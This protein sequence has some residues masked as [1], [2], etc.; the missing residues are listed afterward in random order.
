MSSGEVD[1]TRE[2]PPF[3]P[4]K[5]LTDISTAALAASTSDSQVKEGEFQMA[6]ARSLSRRLGYVTHPEN[7]VVGPGSTF[8]L[9]SIIDQWRKANP[10]AR[11][12][13]PRGSRACVVAADPLWIRMDEASQKIS[14]ASLKTLLHPRDLVILS[15]PLYLWGSIASDEDI[16]ALG[17]IIYSQKAILVSDEGGWQTCRTPHASYPSLGAACPDRTIVLDSMSHKEYLPDWRIGVA[18]FGKSSILQKIRLGVKGHLKE[19][20]LGP[21]SHLLG[22]AAY[23]YSLPHMA[24]SAERTHLIAAVLH[25]LR[26]FVYREVKSLVKTI[27]LPRGGSCIMIPF[28]HFKLEQAAKLGLQVRDGVDFG[29]PGYIPLF[30]TDFDGSQ[31]LTEAPTP[32]IYVKDDLDAWVETWAPTIYNGVDLL[33]TLLV[34]REKHP[35]PEGSSSSRGSSS[36]S[37]PSP[38]SPAEERSSRESDGEGSVASWEGEEEEE[39]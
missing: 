26:L 2:I 27:S 11:L 34:T 38:E 25:A 37:V 39:G 36:P 20:R 13:A 23:A 4:S 31:I 24:A 10:G 1:F 29:C 3:P 15:N 28:P 19:A 30:L 22:G 12:L 14:M 9:Q 35:S 5:S 32:F 8:L 16:L 18:S 17:E 7:V 6:F 33:K 21:P